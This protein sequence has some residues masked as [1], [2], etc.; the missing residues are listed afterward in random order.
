MQTSRDIKRRIRSV[1]NIAQITKAMEVVS[2]NKMRRSQQFALAARPYATAS[3]DMLR[4]ILK[5]SKGTRLPEF[6][7]ARPIQQAVVVVVTTDKGLVGGFNDSV[8][9]LAEQR[10]KMLAE[11][12]IGIH[13]VTVG[14]KARE[15]F[16]RRHTSPELH[17]EQYGD[18][19]A[20]SQTRPIADALLKGYE[21]KTWD[22]VYVIYTHFRTTLK[23]EVVER[24]L[25]PTTEPALRDIV[26]EII[27][28]YGRFSEL[29]NPHEFPTHYNYSYTFEPKAE[30]MI[31]RL[32]ANLLS[33]AMHHIMLESN[34]SEHS[35]R[36]VTMKNAS[37][38]AQDLQESL[39]IVFNKVRQASITAEISEI[40]AGAEALQ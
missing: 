18:Y 31:H 22:A 30:K 34:A 29:K 19:T 21:N 6:L 4:N 25:L 17:F 14:K 37:D 26:E 8:I 5:F 28:E 36:M 2:M 20:F 38:N 12:S 10:L 15:H 27:P 33:I 11:G 16:E 35:T 40:V 24:K 1:K 3:I 32:V 9:R 39:T 7:K 23:Q 13:L